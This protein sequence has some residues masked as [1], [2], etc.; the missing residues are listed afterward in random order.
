MLVAYRLAGLSALEA[1]Y[2]GIDALT[3][4]ERVDPIHPRIP[5]R[6]NVRFSARPRGKMIR[7]DNILADESRRRFPWPLYVA[8]AAIFAAPT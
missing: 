5:E 8:D 6:L 3:Q 4:T 2:A 1:H 7:R